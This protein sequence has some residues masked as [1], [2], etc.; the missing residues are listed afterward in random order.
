MRKRIIYNEE[1][2]LDVLDTDN[3]ITYTSENVI[4]GELY[5]IAPYFRSIGIDTT[6]IDEIE[7]EKY[8][9]HPETS[10]RITIPNWLVLKEEHLTAL[11]NYCKQADVINEVN[12]LN[13]YVYV[14]YILPEHQGLF[15]YLNEKYKGELILIET[16]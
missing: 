13:S 6:I 7:P 14:N 3:S 2:V 1:R 11:I 8:W 10:I 9:P 4:I 12:E 5:K 15:D 16:K